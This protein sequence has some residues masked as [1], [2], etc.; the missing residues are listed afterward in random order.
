MMSWQSLT[1]IT[2]GRSN[3][4]SS[5]DRTGGNA[6]FVQFG[7]SESHTLL[8]CSGPG[9]IEHI[10][11]TIFS[12]DPNYRRNL[13]IR[14]TWDNHEFPSV[15]CP[16]GDFFGNGWGLTYNFSSPYLACAP[17]DGRALVCY[18]PMPFHQNARIEVINQS[19]DH[20]VERLYYYVDYETNV[21]LSQETG[22]FH[23]F[24]NQ[25]LTKPKND[26][27][28]ENEWEILRPYG[29]NPNDEHNYLICQTEGRGHLVG[30]N[31]YVSNP[32][33]M[34]YGEGDDMILIDGAPWPGL[35]GTGT[36]DYFNTS[37]S[38]RQRFDHPFFGIARVPGIENSEPQIGWLGRTHLYRFH[39][40][41]PIRFQTALKFSIEH[42]HDNCLELELATVAY[43]YQTLIQAP[44]APLPD[45][46]SRI[47]RPVTNEWDIHRWRTSWLKENQK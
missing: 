24:F 19:A 12:P 37:W 30:L 17:Q 1:Q 3:R 25:E 26:E 41:D 35:H 34:W 40:L 13:V 43:T 10:W 28:D 18:F 2:N 29:K 22:Y 8:E 33:P 27:R 42:G 31:Y 32:G 14:M 38:P 16:I 39:I 23:A 47:P 44:H 36:E 6:D 7:P 11:I 5:Y 46:K 15:E 45:L 9:V 21:N 4:S 20:P